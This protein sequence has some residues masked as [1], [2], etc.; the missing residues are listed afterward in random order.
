VDRYLGARQ[1]TTYARL[2]PGVT[3]AAANEEL[4]AFRPPR[5]RGRTQ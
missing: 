2:A 3:I 1:L 5:H 4:R